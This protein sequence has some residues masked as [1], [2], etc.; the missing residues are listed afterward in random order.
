MVTLRDILN[1]CPF[2]T[3]MELDVREVDLKLIKHVVIGKDYRPSS[4]QLDD[5]RKGKFEYINADINKYGRAD[6]RGFTEMSFAID[7]KAI[8]KQYLG[9]EVEM[10]MTI[11]ERY[12][13]NKGDRLRASIIPIQM[14]IGDM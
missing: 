10:L 13:N 12:G 2:I 9:M 5:E 1:L 3:L 7:W 6:R 14:T 8:P 4:H 11:S